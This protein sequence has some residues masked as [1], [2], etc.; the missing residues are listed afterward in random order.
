MTN[1]NEMICALLIISVPILVISSCQTQEGAAE[2]MGRNL[3]KA[4]ASVGEQTE[5]TPDRL[6]D[7]ANSKLK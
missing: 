6:K 3:D 5:V 2:Q 7:V 1:L 4:L